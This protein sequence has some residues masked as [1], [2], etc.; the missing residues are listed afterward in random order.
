MHTLWFA[1]S[2]IEMV[3][4]LTS[5]NGT[6][7]E[8][9]NRIQ[10]INCDAETHDSCRSACQANCGV[11]T[12]FSACFNS[13]PQ[14]CAY[15]MAGSFTQVSAG[16][17]VQ[18][19]HEPY[20]GLAGL[21]QQDQPLYTAITTPLDFPPPLRYHR[22]TITKFLWSFQSLKDH[23]T[24][25]SPWAFISVRL[26]CSKCRVLVSIQF[27]G[28]CQI[29]GTQPGRLNGNDSL[30]SWNSQESRLILDMSQAA[31]DAMMQPGLQPNRD[32]GVWVSVWDYKEQN[33]VYEP[34]LDFDYIQDAVE[35]IRIDIEWTQMVRV[36]FS[37]ESSIYGIPLPEADVSCAISSSCEECYAQAGCSW[38]MT[39]LGRVRFMH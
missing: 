28:T 21:S 15:D 25:N 23:A 31:V 19:F 36:P 38:C 22:D 30:T 37:G 2:L 32:K 17:R 16:C 26:P 13:L 39:A 35:S 11:G 1:L 27:S 18:K 14:G 10:S 20:Q 6:I 4:S 8:T 29:A 9:H 33:T 5:W 12:E 3:K 7:I 34:C 24:C